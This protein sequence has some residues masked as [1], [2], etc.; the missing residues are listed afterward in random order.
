M[1]MPALGW[2]LLL[3]SFPLSNFFATFF[4]ELLSIR[5]DSPY[6]IITLD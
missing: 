5:L 6:M 4:I 2:G 3:G 1:P